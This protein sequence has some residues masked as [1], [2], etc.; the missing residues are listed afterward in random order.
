V[1]AAAL[2]D[3]DITSGG[4]ALGL[5]T[6]STYALLAA[7]LVLVFRSSGVINFAH[8]SIGLLGAAFMSLAIQQYGVPYWIAF[9]FG[10]LLSAGAGAATE[11][12]VVKPL[13]RS[14]KVIPMVAM[15]GL[16]TFF[17]VLSLALNPDGLSGEAFPQPAGMPTGE[18]GSLLITKPYAAQG[19]VSPILLLALGMFLWLSKTGLAIRGAAA[20]ADTASMSGVA[21][22][23]MMVWSWAIAGGVSAVAAMFILPT[24]GVVTPESL[25]PE[26]LLRGL[27]AAAIARFASFGVAVAVALVIGV[28]EQ[29][30]ATNPGAKGWIEILILVTVAVAL[31]AERQRGRRTPEAWTEIGAPERRRLAP[32]T[33]GLGIV[34]FAAAATVPLYATA[35]DAVN[36]TV[37]IAVAIVGVSVTLVTG[38]GGQL[39]LAQFALGGLAGAVSVRAAGD[40]VPFPVAVFCGAVIAGAVSALVALPALRVR[41][42]QLAVATLSFSLVTSAYLLDRGWLLGSRATPSR[43]TGSIGDTELASGRGYYWVA[44]VALAIVLVAVRFLRQSAFARQVVAVR[45]NEDAAR[46]LAVSAT[47]V[48]IQLAVVGGAVAGVGGA[49]YAH[50]YTSLSSA[51]FPVSLSID[52]VTVA[53]IGGI[54]SLLGPVIGALYLI[55][56]PLFFQ[57]PAEALAGIAGIWL[58]LVTKEPRGVAGLADTI[59]RR[60][61]PDSDPAALRDVEHH[62]HLADE[63]AVTDPPSGRLLEV[64]GVSRNFGAVVAVDAVDMHVDAGEIVGL[65]G[66]NGAGKTTLFEIISGFTRPTT[67]TVSFLGSDVSRL[68]PTARA[69]RGLGRTFQSAQL[70]PSLSVEET[71]L[72][73]LGRGRGSHDVSRARQ[74]LDEFGILEHRR[75]TVGNLPTG[76]RRVLEMTCAFAARPSLVLLDEPTAGLSSVERDDFADS[77]RAWRDRTGIGIVIIEHDLP[78]LNRVC[79]RLVAMN[80]GRVIAEGR[81]DDVC[82]HPDVVAS[83]TG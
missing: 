20:N 38:L 22:R 10:V 26:L 39:T 68:G 37:V 78:V 49:I 61:R 31:A 28:A 4:I 1:I 32:W 73:A 35:S 56:L 40:G 83:Y 55:G 66:P 82:R 45:D 48:K 67:G 16:S 74:L 12:V 30:L 18:I 70:F 11:V 65:I 46:A 60:L 80:L 36:A 59:R 9:A 77:V 64:S 72:V 43:P 69:R 6:G 7:G 75:V 58:I 57:P 5:F 2:G 51:N 23:S 34:A 8:S 54:G 25:G 62:A 44:L 17:V 71:V 53:V 79:D 41:G 29:L 47:W 33:I 50:A 76:L 81:P 52:A 21:P 13:A 24:A 19:I 27:A 15:L 14:P 42:P 63:H 3:F